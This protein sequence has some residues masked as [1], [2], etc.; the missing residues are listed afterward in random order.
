MDQG[1]LSAVSDD[2]RVHDRKPL[3][4]LLQAA[5]AEERERVQGGG[6]FLCDR[7]L[8]ELTGYRLHRCQ[9]RWLRDRGWPFE[10]AAGGRPSVLR[11]AVVARLGGVRPDRDKPSH[12]KLRWES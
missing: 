6:M 2:I 10:V 3:A 4:T 9:V 8:E 5:R 11:E 7:E 1:A 12:P